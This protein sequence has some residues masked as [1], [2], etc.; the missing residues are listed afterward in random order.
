MQCDQVVK[1]VANC[2]K[3]DVV[4]EYIPQYAYELLK[5]SSI[6]YADDINRAVN[7]LDSHR[8]DDFEIVE[9]IDGQ[10]EGTIDEC[11]H[12]AV[13]MISKKKKTIVL[14]YRGTTDFTQ[15]TDEALSVLLKFKVQSDIGKGEVQNYFKQAHDTLYECVEESVQA[16]MSTYPDYNFL[17]TGHSL[18]GAIASLASARLLYEGIVPKDKSALYT[19]GMP[20]VGDREYALEHNKLVNNSWRVVHGADQV[21]NLPLSTGLPSGPFHHR[22]EVFYTNDRMLPTDT[23]YIV[24]PGSD[25]FSCGRSISLNGNITNDHKIYFGIPVGTYCHTFNGRKRRSIESEMQN[26]FDYTTCSRH[27]NPINRAMLQ[28]HSRAMLRTGY[29]QTAMLL[30]LLT[31]VLFN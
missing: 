12:V 29:N 14:A 26:N 10:C 1:K 17:V 23:D 21:P 13:L 19:F 22:S 7:C 27:R 16:Q 11:S 3:P 5:L 31:C 28:T 18:G 9:W 30:I 15:L 8:M 25:N 4:G 6:P 24:C 2:S 20:R